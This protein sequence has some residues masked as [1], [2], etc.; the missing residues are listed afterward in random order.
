MDERP[1]KTRR[2]R[3]G[4][5]KGILFYALYSI[6]L[7]FYLMFNK[8]ALLVSNDLDTLL[9]NYL[10][11]LIKGIPIVY[12]SHEYYCGVP[13]LINR[14]L[15]RGVWHT[16]EKAIFPKLKHVYTVNDSIAKLYR[17]EYNVEIGVVRNVPIYTPN[18]VAVNRKELNLPENIPLIIYQGAGINIDRGAEEVLL[19]MEFVNNAVL[20]IIGTGDVIEHLK[21]IARRPELNNKIIFISKMP[22]DVLKQYTMQA[23]I[24]LT[25]DKDT[26]PNYRYSLPNKLFDYI[27]ANVPVLASPLIEVKRI[28]EHYNIGKLI[29]NHDPKH[30][31]KKINSMLTNKEAMIRYKENTILA[32]K[33]LNWQKEEQELMKIYSKVKGFGDK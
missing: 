12:D 20:L 31:A 24:G 16:I 2:L 14:P 1:Y 7:F 6:R 22:F 32:A 27:H 30:I 3:I 10:I 33:D 13:E 28:V 5:E 29:E 26:S 19:A 9:P 18:K 21:N 8:A 23:S 25:L 4:V 11:S 15:V 17:D